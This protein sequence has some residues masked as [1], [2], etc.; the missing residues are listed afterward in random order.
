MLMQF[1]DNQQLM[2][3]HYTY[4]RSERSLCKCRKSS[5]PHTSR[6]PS[7]LSHTKDY[8]LS[9]IPQFPYLTHKKMTFHQYVRRKCYWI[10]AMDTAQAYASSRCRMNR[11]FKLPPSF[12]PHALKSRK[13]KSR[14][15]I[16]G[17]KNGKVPCISL[18]SSAYTRQGAHRAQ[19]KSK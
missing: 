16:T 2:F 5:I 19:L 15:L 10:V 9:W 14:G 6:R 18:S 17:T 8:W 11:Q 3:S 7:P 1:R 4:V 13:I 12:H